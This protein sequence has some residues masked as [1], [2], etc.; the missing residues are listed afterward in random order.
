MVEQESYTWNNSNIE[1]V[2][3]NWSKLDF[4][5]VYLRPWWQKSKTWYNSN[6]EKV[7]LS[8]TKLDFVFVYLRPWWLKKVRPEMMQ[9]DNIDKV[10]KHIFVYKR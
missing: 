1:K 2:E 7:E 3:L 10:L 6:I 8:W 4:A 9:I 5:F